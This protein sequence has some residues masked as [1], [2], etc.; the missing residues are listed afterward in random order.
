MVAAAAIVFAGAAYVMYMTMQL[1]AADRA[2][3]DQMFRPL[4]SPP[5]RLVVCRGE[6]DSACA[7]EAADRIGTTVAWLDAPVGYRLE[8]LVANRYVEPVDPTVPDDGVIA[9][10]YFVGGADDRGMFE[11]MTSLPPLVESS[12]PPQSHR[13]VSNGTDTGSLW[14]AEVSGTASVEWMHDG[15]AYL[16]TAQPRPWDPSAVVDAWKTIR[17]ASPQHP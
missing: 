5:A 14:M 16:I 3:I 10:Q 7:Q 1:D 4:S 8:W 17:Y 9:T 12:P 11:V 6:M 2:L 15:I 13:S